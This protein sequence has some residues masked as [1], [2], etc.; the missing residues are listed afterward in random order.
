[1]SQDLRA[2]CEAQEANSLLTGSNARLLERLADPGKG[3]N[4]MMDMSSVI[5]ATLTFLGVAA[6]LIAAVATLSSS[7]TTVPTVSGRTD[8]CAEEA[9]QLREAA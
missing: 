7:S 8:R 6:V 2:G 9:V 3:V 1:M 4:T 5:D